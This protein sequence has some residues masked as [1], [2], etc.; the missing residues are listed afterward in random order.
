MF[1]KHDKIW[2]IGSNKTHYYGKIL[3][4]TGEVNKYKIKYCSNNMHGVL[5]EHIK[6]VSSQDLIKDNLFNIVSGDICTIKNSQDK[7]NLNS[8]LKGII[9]NINNPNLDFYWYAIG[10]KNNDELSG[11]LN[12][13]MIVKITKPTRKEKEKYKQILKKKQKYPKK[14]NRKKNIA[15]RSMDYIDNKIINSHNSNIANDNK[16]DSDNDIEN[17]YNHDIGNEFNNK[18]TKITTNSKD[19]ILKKNRKKKTKK[20]KLKLQ[21][22]TKLNKKYV[23]KTK[24]NKVKKIIIKKKNMKYQIKKKKILQEKLGK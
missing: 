17:Q 11:T 18:I 4:P 20:Q 10:Y 21:L 9:E 1:N 6:V 5:C 24:V 3:K 23:I 8:T 15:I 16:Y 7:N 13:N 2:L 12:R 19:N 22:K 14:Q